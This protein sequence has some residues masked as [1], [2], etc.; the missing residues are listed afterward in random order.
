MDHLRECIVTYYITFTE[1]PTLTSTLHI[2]NSKPPTSLLRSVIFGLL[3]SLSVSSALAADYYMTVHGAGSKDGSSWEH[4]FASKNLFSILNETLLPGDNLY[5]SGPESQDAPHYGD[6]R[7]SISSSGTKEARKALIGVDRGFGV[8]KFV[9]KQKVRSYATFRLTEGSSY[10]TIKNLRIEHREYGLTTDET[11]HKELLIEGI[12]VYSTRASGF[13]FANCDDSIIRNCQSERYSEIGFQFSHSCDRIQ[14]IDCLADC[15]GTRDKDDPGHW[16]GLSDPVG[17]DFHSKRSD[18]APNTDILMKNCIALNNRETKGKYPQGDGIKFERKNIGITL[19]GCLTSRNRDA[20]YDLKGD[21]QILKNCK[22][23]SNSRYGFKLW[24]DGVLTNCV[25]VGHGSREFMLP[26]T[27][28]GERT[29]TARNCTFHGTE[30][31]DFIVGFESKGTTAVLEDCILSFATDKKTFKAGH[32]K[33]VLN[34]SVTLKNAADP[35]N[36]PL[37]VAPTLPWYGQGNNFDNRTFGQ[38]KGYSSRRVI[39]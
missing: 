29:I 2:L 35:E 30:K 27:G 4:A 3:F 13:V 14:I 15:T 36:P 38:A 18:A 11:E 25:S 31:T 37:Y 39:D 20:G 10:W 21:N 33:L 8:P 22:A 5:L 17:F 34:D 26:A 19:D 23:I 12:S 16:K 1:T 28:D 32:G 6:L 24:Y 9:G 7:G